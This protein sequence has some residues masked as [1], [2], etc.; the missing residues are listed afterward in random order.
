[1]LR[2]LSIF[3][4]ACL[5]VHT[6]ASGLSSDEKELKEILANTDKLWVGEASEAQLSM[7]VKTANYSRTLEL[8]YWVK[9][10]KNTMV[11]ITSPK[12]EKGTVTLKINDDMYNYL[13][14]VARTVKVSSALRGGSWMGSHFTND[15]LIRATLLN[16][17]YDA[18]VLNKSTQNKKSVWKIQLIPK[19][20]TPTPWGK[21]VLEL[22]HTDNL[23]MK[24][25]YYDEDKKLVRTI[26]YSNV[27]KMGDR[28]VPT[29]IKVIPESKKGEYTQLTYKK[30][31]YSVKLNDDFFSLTRIENL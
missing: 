31:D 1:M 17:S 5:L 18:T 6:Q 22:N 28:Q 24:Q 15:D 16:D 19:K 10:K 7:N 11:L 30:I 26:T 23:P 2:L 12:K 21:I 3:S 13:P 14:K 20:N 9:G 4:F 8:K 27:K 25:Q 29:I